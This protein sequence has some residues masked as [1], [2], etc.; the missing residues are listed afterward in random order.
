MK[1]GATLKAKN[2]PDKNLNEFWFLYA[3]PGETKIGAVQE[4]VTVGTYDRT[5]YKLLTPYAYVKLAT[6]IEYNG[7]VY[8][9]AYIREASVYEYS[10]NLTTYYVKPTTKSVN[11]RSSSKTSSSNNIIGSLTANQIV[12]TT[13]GTTENNFFKFNLAKG[14]TGWVSRNYITST[15]PAGKPSPSTATTT[16]DVMSDPADDTALQ[17]VGTEVENSVGTSGLTVL[18]WVGVGLLAIALGIVVAR[19]YKNRSRK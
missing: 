17:M 7:Q 10:P 3:K 11:V 12:G 5:Q 8:R 2:G 15:I 14:G 1:T 16:P 9:Y 4:G 13:D 18:K 6:P 19:I